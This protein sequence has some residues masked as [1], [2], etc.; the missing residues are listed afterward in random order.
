MRRA[1]ALQQADRLGVFAITGGGSG[2]ISEILSTPGASKSVLEVTVPY[3]T[4]ALA[5][6]LGGAPEQACSQATARALAMAAF[7]RAR[8]LS[9]PHGERA[10][11]RCFGLACTASLA[12]DRPKRGRYR[13]HLALQTT[14]ESIDC[15]VELSPRKARAG[16]EEDLIAA[17]WQLLAEGF[18]LPIRT[19]SAAEVS[20]TRTRARVGWRHLVLGEAH[21]EAA[22]GFATGTTAPPPALLL[23]GSF[24]PLHAG[25]RDMLSH[26]EA[27][28]GL[29]GAFELSIQN[30]DKPPLDYTTIRERLK[31]FQ[32][33]RSAGPIW[34]TRLPT[35]IEKA[36][37]F[38]GVVFAVGAD[39]IV[40]VGMS[41]YYGSDVGL[42]RA[43]YELAEQ[44]V[45]FLVFGREVDGQFKTL[46]QLDIPAALRRLCIG[47][48]KRDFE[49]DLSSTALRSA[50]QP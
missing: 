18:S 12:T 3:A 4:G 47:V 19:R 46:Q 44:E 17:L 5:S 40:R 45:K 8:H 41:K 20:I 33:R 30:V 49:S 28:L 39:T 38:P 2:L 11:S 10:Q 7:Q 29:T 32:G 26:A 13:A 27:T 34:L 9:A 24:N 21:C 42:K 15:L 37:A 43:L 1:L 36:Q 31:P 25:H 14:V 50:S 22:A 6:Y 16:H 35:F 23:P 48:S